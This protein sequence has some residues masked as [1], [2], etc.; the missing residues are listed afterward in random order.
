MTEILDVEFLTP[1]RV[2]LR[3][4]GQEYVRQ[5]SIDLANR[6]VYSD[7]AEVAAD[8]QDMVFKFLDSDNPFPGDFFSA[9]DEIYEKAQDAF[10]DA[11]RTQETHVGEEH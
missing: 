10:E 5:I 3:D 2:T 9:S 1:A 11:R 4:G 6:K 8:L 7:S